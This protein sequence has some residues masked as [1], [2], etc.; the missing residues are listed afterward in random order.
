MKSEDETWSLFRTLSENYMHHASLSQS[1]KQAPLVL[2]KSLYE[3]SQPSGITLSPKEW[4]EMKL[5]VQQ[6]RTRAFLTP[7]RLVTL[8]VCSIFASPLHDVY[9]CP[10]G[11][12]FAEI[13][14]ES[15]NATQGYPNQG[16]N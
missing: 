12:Q 4:E 5:V 13:T 6:L 15:M 9:S 1:S 16:N 10:L 7:S 14:E 2:K 11:A 3:V 8:D